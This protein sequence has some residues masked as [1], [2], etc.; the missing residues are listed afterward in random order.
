MSKSIPS[1]G[2]KAENSN[3]A[4]D[5]TS[6]PAIANALV[7]SSLFVHSFTIEKSKTNPGCLMLVAHTPQGSFSVGGN[8]YDCRYVKPFNPND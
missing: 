8:Y 6:R 5:A 1:A 7:G 2:T 3:V 4:E